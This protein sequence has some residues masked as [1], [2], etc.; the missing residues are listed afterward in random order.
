M[1]RA[2]KAIVVP[3]LRTRGFT[4]S[5]PHFR[6]I[7]PDRIDLVSFHF[8]RRGGQFVVELSQCG[9]AGIA[10]EGEEAIP[11]DKVTVND[12]FPGDRFCLRAKAGWRGELAGWRGKLFVFDRPTYDP[13]IVS[14]E[15]AME[16][17]CAKT[18]RTALDAFT[19][20]AEPWW[21]KKAAATRT[22]GG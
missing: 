9:P 4:G 22:T 1:D 2:L 12:T 8:P 21:E 11:P 10:F 14:T 13:P 19:R 17:V 15:A 5:F 16:G 6:R 3:E 18:A 20:E 7:R